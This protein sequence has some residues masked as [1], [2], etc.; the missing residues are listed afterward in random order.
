LKHV[1]RYCINKE[2]KEIHNWVDLRYGTGKHLSEKNFV[3]ARETLGWK[4]TDSKNTFN[5][6]KCKANMD[7]RKLSEMQH[8]EEL[9][10]HKIYDAGQR[11]WVRKL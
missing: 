5:R 9:G 2:I 4:W 7:D 11:L 1:E 10:W 6:L 3:F 8:A